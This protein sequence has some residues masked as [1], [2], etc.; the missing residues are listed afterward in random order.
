MYTRHCAQDRYWVFHSA[1]RMNTP[2]RSPC[3]SLRL[4]PQKA[5]NKTPNSDPHSSLNNFSDST[6][7][8]KRSLMAYLCP[9]SRRYLNNRSFLIW[10]GV[11]GDVLGCSFQGLPAAGSCGEHTGTYLLRPQKGAT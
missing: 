1:A 6:S 4:L 11:R 10:N 7:G 2:L 8:N 5:L 9:H 3:S